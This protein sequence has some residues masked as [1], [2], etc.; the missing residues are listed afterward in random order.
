MLLIFGGIAALYLIWLAFRAAAFALPLYAGLSL[1]IHMIAEGYGDR[2]AILS[3][4]AAGTGLLVIGRIF[5]AIVPSP[6]VR[7]FVVALFAVPAGFA[8]YQFTAGLGAL[9]M[10]PG[11]ILVAGSAIAAVV[12]A[13]SAA[14]ALAFPAVAERRSATPAPPRQTVSEAQAD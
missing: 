14:S 10:E 5:A 8:G 2:A 13:A 9:L 4:F 6:G 7:L 12:A 11:P 1:T 3:G